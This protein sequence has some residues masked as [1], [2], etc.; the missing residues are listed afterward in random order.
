MTLSP[1]DVRLCGD[2]ENSAEINPAG[3]IHFPVISIG[4]NSRP[5]LKP[6]LRDAPKYQPLMEFESTQS[7][8]SLQRCNKVPRRNQHR[9]STP[10]SRADPIKRQPSP[11]LWNPYPTLRRPHPTRSHQYSNPSHSSCRVSRPTGYNPTPPTP[12]R[13]HITLDPLV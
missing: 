13:I 8:R 10:A 5:R 6:S 11:T 4:L 12:A 1:S 3:L 2:S 9:N 7:V